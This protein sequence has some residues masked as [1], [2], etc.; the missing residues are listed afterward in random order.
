MQWKN[1]NVLVI[2][3]GSSGVCSAELLLGEGASVILYDGNAQLQE[4]NIRANFQTTEKLHIIL[5]DF[6]ENIFS[7]ITLAIVSPGVPLDIP[8]LCK[9]KECGIAIWG[10]IELAYICGAGRV[11][12]ITGTN[13]KTTT[14]TLL[15]AIMK[16]YYED[17][18]IVGNIGNPYTKVAKQTC[19]NS[20][21]VAELSSFQLETIYRFHPKISAILN[22][23][24]DHLDRHYTMEAYIKAKVNIAKNQT[25]ED[26]CVLNYDDEVVKNLAKSTQAR[27]CFFSANNAVEYGMYLQNSELIYANETTEVLCNVKELKVL[28]VHNYE[29]IMAAS[30]MALTFGVPIETVREVV[31]GFEGVAHRIEYVGEYEGVKYYNDSKGTNP[32]AAIK[33]IQAMERP[34]FLIA[35]GYDKQADYKEWIQSFDGK[36]KKLVLLGATK[37]TIAKQARELGF[38]DVVLVETLE[39]AVCFCREQAQRDEVVLLSP[40]CA[41]WGMF[42]NYEQRGDA[43]KEIVKKGGF[44]ANE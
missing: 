2:G 21:I 26:I 30:L 25:K 5:G 23:S 42:Q 36:V 15:G 8:L 27:V 34:T 40:A 1:E 37:E 38:E 35:G 24:P 13:G 22:L 29:N 33:A 31:K 6:P 3:S 11:L 16:A 44:R 41:S 12:G 17:V 43:F 28:G 9:V 10:E 7:K 20:V 18:Y 14:T 39:A 32:D 4:D 19:A